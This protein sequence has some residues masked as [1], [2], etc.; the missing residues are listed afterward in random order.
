MS[1]KLRDLWI[2]LK[3]QQYQDEKH[4]FLPS[5]RT[6]HGFHTSIIHF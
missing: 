2:Q 5:R 4:N 6:E 3:V 1:Q